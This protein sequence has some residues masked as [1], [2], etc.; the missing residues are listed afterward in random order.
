MIWGYPGGVDGYGPESYD[1]LALNSTLLSIGLIPDGIPA[2]RA[3]RFKREVLYKDLVVGINRSNLWD[4][5]TGDLYLF[6]IESEYCIT[7]SYS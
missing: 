1:V 5:D 6:D 3:E 2:S 7:I 4:F